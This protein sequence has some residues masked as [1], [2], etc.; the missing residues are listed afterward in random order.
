MYGERGDPYAAVSRLT[1]RL[2]AATAP[3][4]ALAGVAEA[5]AIS[6]R[7]PYVAVETSAGITAE[8]GNPGGGPRHVVELSHQGED[9]G[10]LVVEGRDG[11]PP[12]P[13]D[14]ALLGD[15]ARP[16]GAA[17]QSAALADAL[18][19]SQRRLVE[20][21]EEERRR[22]RRDLHD[23]L[24]P[25]LAGVVLGID[26]ASK[27]LGDDQ[28]RARDLLADV[29]AEASGAVDDIRRLVYDLRPPALDELGLPGAV[30]QQAERLSLRRADLGIAVTT[31]GPLP[32]LSAATEVAAYRIATEALTN[33]VRHAHAHQCSVLL[34]A[35]GQLRVEVTDDGI[36][37]V[38]G[39][40]SGVGLTTM[41]ERATELGG[42]CTVS[43]VEPAGTRVVA[44][45]PLDQR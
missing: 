42:R 16:A 30:R 17:V 10:R 18:Q 26:A 40:R 29:K 19:T 12:T 24:G 43:S 6:L 22:L 28:G 15:L 9:V 31:T 14:L 11:Q 27:L 5:I 21:R 34:S 23:G 41:Q 45:L 1:A 8:H 33:A 35:D 20:A 13:R 2:Q 36:G 3:G 25:T 38:A 44:V 4:D 32:P 39:A 7:L 37:I